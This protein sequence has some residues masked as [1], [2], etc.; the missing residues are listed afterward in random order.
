[1]FN[2]VGGIE[3]AK[4][5][6]GSGGPANNDPSLSFNNATPAWCKCG[7][8]RLANENKCSKQRP[9]TPTF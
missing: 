5:I 2:H 3:S 4:V 9:T 1:M 7:R 6:L 8:C